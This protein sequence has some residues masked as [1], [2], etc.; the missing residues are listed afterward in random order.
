MKKRISLVLAFLFSL[1]FQGRAYAEENSGK[2]LSLDWTP[3]PDLKTADGKISFKLR[4]RIFWDN[5][6]IDDSDG[7]LNLNATEFRTARIGMDGKLGK[8]LSFTFE[9]D[10]AHKT[11]NYKTISI[12][13]NGPVTVE[14]GHMKFADPFE[15]SSSSRF[16]PFMERGGY[17]NAFGFGRQF[18]IGVTKASDKGLLQTGIFQGGF[19]NH[20]SSSTGF[21]FAAR[22]TRVIAFGK[23]LVHLGTT[24]RYREIGDNQGNFRFRHRPHQHLAPRFVDTM[25]LATSDLF[26]GVEGGVFSGPFQATGELGILWADMAMPLVGQS[27][28]TFWGGHITFGYFLTGEDASY[29]PKSGTFARPKVKNPLFKG[30]LGAVQAT[31]RYDYIDLTDNGVFGGIQK[32]FIT[33]LNWW[34]SPHTKIVVNYSHSKVSQA[35]LVAANGADGANKINAV[36]VRTQIDW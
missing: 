35:F 26:V 2:S 22:A 9:A 8:Q 33:G 20:G 14:G 30:G 27:D 13:W 31:V 1:L 25:S 29:N 3:G 4:G 34:L 16:L 7:T 23:T 17:N 21:K 15:G 19:T 10:F 12:R 32:T 24:F 36:G 6:W 5:A 28:P 11:V 18:G